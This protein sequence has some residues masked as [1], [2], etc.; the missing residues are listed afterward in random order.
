VGKENSK[1]DKGAGKMNIYKLTCL[2]TFI[3][4]LICSCISSGEFEGDINSL[5]DDE[6]IL[7]GSIELIPPLEEGEQKVGG[8]GVIVIGGKSLKNKLFLALGENILTYRDATEK[9]LNKFLGIEFEKLFNIK[10]KYSE[11][12]Y[13]STPYVPLEFKSYMGENRIYFPEP[14]LIEITRDCKIAY[15]GRICFYRDIYN[16]FTKIEIRDEYDETL[17]EV[18]EIFGEDVEMCRARVTLVQEE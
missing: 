13:I 5:K 14:F 12:L 3:T 16:E 11:K 6:I 4:F 17:V 8:S 7:V 18:K 2:Y 15:L 1:Q 9:N 10:Q